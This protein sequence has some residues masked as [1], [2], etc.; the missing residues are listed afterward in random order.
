MDQTTSAPAYA[1]DNEYIDLG[2]LFRE[3][4]DKE[5]DDPNLLAQLHL[6][7]AHGS[8]TWDDLLLSERVVIL[9][10][11]GSGKSREL[12]EQRAR[13]ADGQ[14]FAFM[15]P[16]EALQGQDVED[17]LDFEDV[18]LDRFKRWR[19]ETTESAWVFLD[20]VDELK[21]TSG[22]LDTALGKVARALGPARHRARI[23]LTCRPTDW[24]PV[25]DME[26]F[27]KRL[28]TSPPAS[29]LPL[30]SDD[31]EFL[32]GIRGRSAGPT[33]EAAAPKLRV[34]VLEGLNEPQIK[35]FATHKGI[36]DA[37]G[38]LR[39]I[40]RREAWTFA[41]RPLDL[42]G[43]ARIWRLEGRIGTARQQHE[44][45]VLLSLRDD[46]ERADAGLLSEDEA[47]EGAERLALAL[48][49]TRTRTIKVP[50]AL[51]ND[52]VDTSMLD[53]EEVLGDWTAAK[54]NALLRRP[55]FDVATY[56]RVRFH[57]RS[58]GEYLAACRLRKLKAAGLSKRQLL[59]ILF[60]DLYGE[61]IVIPSMRAIAAW[62]A[63][64]DED[65]FS[66]VASREP[67]VLIELGDA[68]SLAPN[69]RDELIRS[70]V[71]EYGMG[72]WRGIE[73]SLNNVQRLAD[74]DAA[75][76]IRALLEPGVQ[77][78][79][80]RRFLLKL[81]W[82]GAIGECADL[83]LAAAMN[84]G[85][86]DYSRIIGLRALKECGRTD[87][88]RKVADDILSNGANWPNKLLHTVPDILY[89][90]VITVDE[91]AGILETVPECADSVGGFSWNLYQLASHLV[92][93]SEGAVALR[94]MLSD[95]VWKGYNQASL[96]H[97]PTSSFDFLTPALA[98]LCS[99]ELQ[100]AASPGPE[101][102]RDAV[103]AYRFHGD[104]VVGQ[105]EYRELKEAFEI[106]KPGRPMAHAAEVA[107]TKQLAPERGASETLSRTYG[108]GMISDV[109][110]DDWPWLLS[111][112]HNAKTA[113]ARSLLFEA[114]WRAL[115]GTG[116][117]ARLSELQAATSGFPDLSTLLAARVAPRPPNPDQEKYERE[118]QANREEVDR[119]K[120]ERDDSWREWRRV[121][122]ADPVAA[123]SSP[124][125][126]ANLA[127]MV[128]WLVHRGGGSGSKYTQ[129]NWS[130]VRAVFGAEVAENFEA[131]I[132]RY[133]RNEPADV[134]SARAHE[135]RSRGL[136]YSYFGLTG[137]AVD[138]ASGK[139]WAANLSEAEAE[140][141]AAW[142]TTEMNGFPEWLDQLIEVHPNAVFAAFKR[143][144]DAELEV[145]D[146]VE[147]PRTLRSIEHGPPAAKRLMAP[148]LKQRLLAWPRETE[149][150][151]VRAFENLDT[152]RSVVTSTSEGDLE[153][154]KFCGRRFAA[155]P[156]GVLAM[157]WLRGVFASDFAEGT[158]ALRKA[159]AKFDG[160]ER[161]SL[162][163]AWLA[164]IF[165]DRFVS[166]APAVATSDPRR[167]KALV[168]LAY[169]CIRRE[170]DVE[171]EGVYT[172]DMRDNAETARNY[173][174]GRLFNLPGPEAH[175]VLLELAEEP[176]F[177][178]MPDRLRLVARER[179]AQD[180]EPAAIS[181]TAFRQ[182]EARLE[183]APRNPQELFDVVGDRLN[184]MQFDLVHHDFGHRA[185][186]Q[187][188]TDET[189]L[190]PHI[191]AYLHAHARDHFSVT[192]ESEAADLKKRDVELAAK[193]FGG[194]ATVEI[195]VGDNCSVVDL[196]KAIQNQLV[197]RYLR[198]PE[199]RV[200]YLLVTFAGRT[201]QL[202]KH[203]DTG[204]LIEFPMVIEHLNSFA[205]QLMREHPNEI[206]LGVAGFDL[207]SPVDTPGSKAAL[208]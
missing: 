202:F 91:L 158:K 144:L 15:I 146:A 14:R 13:L 59:R 203:P 10:E 165:G 169:E 4:T 79:E 177:A 174:L 90:D 66:F 208:L 16:I 187:A 17:Y 109:G 8:L 72:D 2:R 40:R 167:L 76:E 21:L 112:F 49:R 197:R 75:R 5:R 80:A 24:R 58:V 30:G 145:P 180:S 189:E 101:L 205:D 69:A 133:W 150:L 155:R 7:G 96:W 186:L 46:P 198:H 38:F 71:S 153:V 50:E 94:K 178:H 36:T 161:R 160:D 116:H 123:F 60:A 201:K 20:A 68:E 204:K 194:R 106:G 48:A 92:A 98:R 118:R 74:P 73:L 125:E 95:L 199:N 135:D 77:N 108:Y 200:G 70:F 130:H 99:I 64:E 131:S 57:H 168:E 129:S 78:E 3:L 138:V 84:T 62:M 23:I 191:A 86:E 207:R 192:R 140:K 206:R 117:D 196:Q 181:A 45:D 54:R 190:Q 93:G 159:L 137:V 115:W 27:S 85:Y 143:E 9:A 104:R 12:Q 105:T 113:E 127:C 29:P 185:Q 81:I 42:M 119:R 156:K 51:L 141:A 31:D 82:L 11:A 151:G 35:K 120:T 33:S 173:I 55:I 162:G 152:V 63:I 171:H 126:K 22:K 147:Y 188:L 52:H 32:S 47:R 193:S 97:H 19:D 87:L 114:L 107:L 136:D 111:D 100:A 172:P 166:R 28:P 128:R 67:E 184:D 157:A 110:S 164:T 176:L 124:E 1:Q 102:V 175:V 149:G 53:P 83:A 148:L 121:V 163:A 56:G 43:L 154:A 34:V 139:D 89:P 142:A 65:V 26:A 44:N 179:A 103:I 41:R 25:Q 170:D 182:W 134:W 183:T 88:L 61:K 122:E 195:K 132:R 39:E 37:E 18:E 6:I